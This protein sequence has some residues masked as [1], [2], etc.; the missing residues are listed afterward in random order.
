MILFKSLM[1][2]KSRGSKAYL[3]F[4]TEPNKGRFFFPHGV[5]NSSYLYPVIVLGSE[6]K[7]AALQCFL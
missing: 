5:Q 1:L 4:F 2:L 6:E 3:L 7:S